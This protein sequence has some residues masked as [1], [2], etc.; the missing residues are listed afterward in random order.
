MGKEDADDSFGGVVP[1][2]ADLPGAVGETLTASGTPAEKDGS[3]YFG[4][5]SDD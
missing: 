1:A 3:T 2:A 5:A 4:V